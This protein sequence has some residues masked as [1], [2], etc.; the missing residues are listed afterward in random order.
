MSSF[1]CYVELLHCAR[2]A[3]AR[4]MHS[5]DALRQVAED[6]RFDVVCS[7]CASSCEEIPQ[8]V[9]VTK[10]SVPTCKPV[11]IYLLTR[12]GSRDTG[13]HKVYMNAY[14]W[15]FCEGVDCLFP[16]APSCFGLSRVCPALECSWMLSLISPSPPLSWETTYRR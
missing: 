6:C 13:T 5:S 8:D 3:A 15:Y 11:R 16:I 10:T 1:Q 12:N 7:R 2:Q 9:T 4:G 14:M